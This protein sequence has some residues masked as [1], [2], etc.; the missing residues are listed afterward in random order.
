MG[1]GAG[2]DAGSA[3]GLGGSGPFQD[4]FVTFNFV[5]VLD[6]YP[7]TAPTF[8]R[9]D[10]GFWA[11]NET[12][13]IRSSLVRTVVTVFQRPDDFRFCTFTDRATGPVTLSALN[14]VLGCFALRAA[15][16]PT[17]LV[18]FVRFPAGTARADA[19]A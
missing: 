2:L 13:T 14:A 15:F 18:A 11:M 16:H 6:R 4:A 19:P 3:W 1:S 5:V 8:K 7:L 17:T 9:Q 10:P 12:S